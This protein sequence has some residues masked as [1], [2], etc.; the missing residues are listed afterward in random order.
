[1]STVFAIDSLLSRDQAIFCFELMLQRDHEAA[2]VTLAHKQGGI[3]GRVEFHK[4]ISSFLAK[5][6]TDLKGLFSNF[7]VL[8]SGAKS[9]QLPVGT[10]ELIIFS[11]GY[12]HGLNI[13]SNIKTAV[14]VYE[15]DTYLDSN[16]VNGFQ[17][18]FKAY[19]ND[20]RLKNLKKLGKVAVSSE[21]LK[22]Q[23]GLTGAQVIAPTFKTED[24][25]FV[26][27]EDH[28]F[29]FTHTLVYTYGRS[30]EELDLLFSVARELKHSLKIMG[31]DT[32]LAT[33]KNKY[34][35]VEFIGD[36]CEATASMVSHQAKAVCDFSISAFPSRAFGAFCN[37]RPSVVLDTPVYREYLPTEMSFFV[38]EWN[39]KSLTD[40][41]NEIDAKYLQFDRKVLR[42]AGLKWNERLFK[43]KIRHFLEQ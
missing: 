32:H 8:P 13:P 19:V 3:L 43:A 31:P 18:F 10:T 12:I 20:W 37:G 15:W 21:T 7:W 30:E 22:K 28:N 23:L 35:E 38:K 11:R 40:L 1:M 36:H 39:K 24:Y 9:L 2:I 5:K 34:P 27:D 33:L 6:V 14:Y 4:V 16:K 25:S 17:K 26:K 41:L 42:R 29:L